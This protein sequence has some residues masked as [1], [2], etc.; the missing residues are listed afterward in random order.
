[1]KRKWISILTLVGVVFFVLLLRTFICSS[2]SIPSEGMEN[3][4]L[5]GDRILVNKWSY[6]LRSPL[7]SIFPYHRWKTH[8]AK[9]E[10]FV[11]FNNPGNTQKK[12]LDQKEIFINRCTGIPGDTIWVDSLYRYFKVKSSNPDR[13]RLFTY[14]KNRKQDLAN[15]LTELK[16]PDLE[17]VG[18]DSLNYFSSFSQYEYYLI[19]QKIDGLSW[20]HT[21]KPATIYPIIVPGKHITVAVKPWNITLLRNTLIL[22]ENRKAEI[23]NDTLFVESQPTLNCTFTKDYYWMS[24]SNPLNLSDSRIFGFVPHDHLIGKA[25]FIWLSKERNNN[26]FKGYRSNR[27]FTHIR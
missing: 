16:L 3:N 6:G 10:D 20:F 12:A 13:K 7:L 18:E 17:V 21:A 11:V 2:Y 1:M 8:P 23:K 4:L 5:P 14:P 19:S 22:H 26:P 9:K 25:F 24:S 27:C 15:L